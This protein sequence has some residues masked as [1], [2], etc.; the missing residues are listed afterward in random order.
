MLEHQQ[1]HLV[2]SDNVGLRRSFLLPHKTKQS[3]HIHLM[4]RQ[5]FKTSPETVRSLWC[6]LQS[7]RGMFFENCHFMVH[8]C[9][10]GQRRM[11]SY[12]LWSGYPTIRSPPAKWLCEYCAK[13]WAFV[14]IRETIS[15]KTASKNIALCSAI[16]LDLVEMLP[17]IVG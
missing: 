14:L 4:I 17:V 15:Q 9:F 2:Q 16:S 3:K 6:Y 10:I 12:V 5:V 11:E 7:P 1:S 8:T 13:C